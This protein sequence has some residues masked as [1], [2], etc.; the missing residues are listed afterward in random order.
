MLPRVTLLVLLG[1]CAPA[2]GQGGARSSKA[3]A[4]ASKPKGILPVPDYSG[5]WKTR[6]KVTGDWGGV[7]QD[8]ANS[9]V[10]I[11]LDWYQSYQAIVHGGRREDS[12]YS[13]NLDYRVT[14]DLMRMGAIPGALVSFR[15][16]SLFGETVNSNTGLLLPVNTYSAFPISPSSDGEV[17][18]AITELNW[19][20]LLS[21][22]FGVLAGKIT[23]IRTANEF[24][25]GAGNTQFMNFQF[26]FPSVL[27][28]VAPYS[29]LAAGV[30]WMPDSTW[31][32][33]STVMNLEDAST[34]TGFDDI[35]DGATWATTVDYLFSP[36]T[37]PGGGTFGFYYA[38]DG[39]FARIGGINLRPRRGPVIEHQST[40]WALSWNGWQYLT[41]EDDSAKVDPRNGRQDLQ[42]LGV[43]ANL[44][45]ADKDTNPVAWTVA[46]GL[47]GRGSIPGRDAD[48]WG[49]GVY[50]NDLQDLRLGPLM[51]DQ[52]TSGLE[53]YYDIAL[54]GSAF[55]T[56][57]AQW[58]QSAVPRVDDATI[59]GAR[60]VINF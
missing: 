18:F 24:M 5:D 57:D 42:G 9:G 10:T 45:V 21:E 3:E 17:D 48:T 49:V 1:L 32:I 43:F 58:T 20:Q 13:T 19:L 60:L 36:A 55:L 14:L 11:G 41:V 27:A 53:A 4:S 37:L 34:T 2:F 51:L 56:F 12:E 7:R 40:T 16:Q 6:S 38:F 35:G 44:G 15:A 23:T 22:E 52:S 59:L 39:E 25:G 8:W 31:T 30:L 47:S 29:T 33:T 26:I 54:T 50:Y 28:Q 46:G